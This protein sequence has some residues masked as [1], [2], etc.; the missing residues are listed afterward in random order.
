VTKSLI[1]AVFDAGPIIHLDELNC[2]DLINDFK[3]IILSDTVWK[4]INKNRPSVF[5]RSGVSLIR[6]PQKHLKSEPLHTLCR[7]FSLD[8]GEIEALAIMARNQDAVFF[9]DDASARFVAE[10]MG[11]KVHGTIG[12]I[13]RSTR[14]KQ[15][16]PKQVLQILKEIPLKS[17][18]Y[19][20]ASLLEEI[21][22]EFKKEFGL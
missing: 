1:K 9:T 21:I 3:E 16:R 13:I 18:L 2:L 10:Q 15:M 11:F 12:I 20:K 7:T 17:T 22:S 5:K 19:I 14:R 4:E 6:S 8:A